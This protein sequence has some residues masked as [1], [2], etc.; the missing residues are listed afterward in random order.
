MAWKTA[1][2]AAGCQLV[3]KCATPPHIVD[4]YHFDTTTPHLAL[5]H[6]WGDA[7]FL[8]LESTNITALMSEIP[9]QALSQTH[10]DLLSITRRLGHRYISIDLLC[11]YSHRT[12]MKHLGNMRVASHFLKGF[13]SMHLVGQVWR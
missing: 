1:N 8:N 13:N 3:V 9:I 4:A 5:S 11:I 7:I 10:R 6:S 12:A 2:E